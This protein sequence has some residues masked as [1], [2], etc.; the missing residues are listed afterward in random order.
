M[1]T[2]RIQLKQHNNLLNILPWQHNSPHFKGCLSARFSG[3]LD[4]IFSTCLIAL[5]LAKVNSPSR[6]FS[7]FLL[8]LKWSKNFAP[9]KCLLCSIFSEYRKQILFGVCCSGHLNTLKTDAQTLLALLLR[10]F[11]H[12]MESILAWTVAG[13]S[14]NRSKETRVENFFWPSKTTQALNKVTQIRARDISI[15]CL[16]FPL[17]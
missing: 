10:L 2:K 14:N 16:Q 15:I 5:L 9:I 3:H 7:S 6:I 4:M 12:L 8:I 13:E 11:C 17:T 1:N